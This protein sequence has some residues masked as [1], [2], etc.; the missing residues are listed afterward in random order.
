M[1]KIFDFLPDES[2]VGLI[3]GLLKNHPNYQGVGLPLGN[4]TSQIF[5]NFYLA[6]LDELMSHFLS[7]RYLRY[8][9]DIVLLGGS[10]EE[11]LKGLRLAVNHGRREKLRFPLR[12][13]L[14]LGEGSAIPF[15]GFL[16]GRE[17]VHPLNRNRRRISQKM[18]RKTKIG[19]EPSHVARAQASYEA[20]RTYPLR[21]V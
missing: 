4:L 14:W 17:G 15:L 9:D 20:W 19:I 7:G 1:G 18:R 21:L 12:K 16:V 10:R 3:R 2:C 6:E 13:R 11:A 5:A 8:M